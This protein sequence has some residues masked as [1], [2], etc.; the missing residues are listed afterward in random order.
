MR[1]TFSS[2]VQQQMMSL[3]SERKERMDWYVIASPFSNSVTIRE[4]NDVIL[5]NIDRCVTPLS[6]ITPKNLSM[7]D[8]YGWTG[9]DSVS[10]VQSFGHFT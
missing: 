4:N 10:F 6:C 5:V 8:Q 1:K 3:V 2:L 9:R 7:I